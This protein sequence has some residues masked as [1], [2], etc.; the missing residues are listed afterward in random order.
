LPR[1]PRGQNAAEVALSSATLQLAASAN[2]IQSGDILHV[3]NAHFIGR[4]IRRAI[5]SWGNH[6]GIFVRPEA[7]LCIGESTWPRSQCTDLAT[8]DTRINS[9]DTQ[10]L[11]LRPTG[12]YPAIGGATAMQGSLAAA[13][14]LRNAQGRPYDLGAYPRLLLKSIFGDICQRAAGWEWAWYCTESCRDA[15]R[16]GPGLDPWQKTNPTPR[17]TE[18]RFESGAFQLIWSSI[19]ATEASLPRD[20]RG[21]GAAEVAFPFTTPKFTEP[22]ARFTAPPMPAC[23]ATQSVAGM[24][25]R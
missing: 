9:G 8:Y 12:V 14:W 7:E 16:N 25:T 21:R 24:S 15:W 17:T 11:V 23:I 2:L 22:T 3:R 13:W 18:K 19:P 10:V 6:N 4:A 1:D 20:S 5:G